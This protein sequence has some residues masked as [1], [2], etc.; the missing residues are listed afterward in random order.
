MQFCCHNEGSENPKYNLRS[1]ATNIVSYPHL[2]S[3]DVNR[4]VVILHHKYTDTIK[5]KQCDFSRA[6]SQ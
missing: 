1:R 5:K 3:I 2:L 6:R 4:S